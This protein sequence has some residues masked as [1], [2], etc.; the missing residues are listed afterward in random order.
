LSQQ[1]AEILAKDR[2]RLTLVSVRFGSDHSWESYQRTQQKAAEKLGVEFQ[3]ESVD[4]ADL[5]RGLPERLRRLSRSRVHGIIIQQP[6]PKE[7]EK[8]S[9]FEELDP[10][11]D[12]EGIHPATLG[13]LVL[14]EPKLVPCTALACMSLIDATG[15][16]C[17]GKQ[18]VIIGQS[19]IV[20]RPVQLL[21]GERRA[22]TLLCNTGTSEEVM[23]ELVQRA[24]IVVACAGKP[25]LI[26]GRWI[27]EGALVIDV[28][29][30]R[31]EG[32]IVGDIEF[33]EAKKRAGYITPVP[34]GVGPLTVT[35]LMKNLLTAYRWQSE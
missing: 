30:N 20:G 8:S 22:T 4:E 3:V 12:V 24:D 23:E 2:V 11:K 32:K 1:F 33:E 31:V 19:A 25:G 10:K 6:L 34:G 17:R 18:A 13:Y 29:T 35:M 14:R 15:I 21:L 5:K 16:D 26:R 28:G 9:I 27:K 7:V